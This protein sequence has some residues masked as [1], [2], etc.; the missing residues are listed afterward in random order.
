MD[1]SH[2]VWGQWRWDE[3]AAIPR[4]AP[5]FADDRLASGGAQADDHVRADGLEFS[6]QPRRT[7]C[8]FD[9]AGLF[10]NAALAA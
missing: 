6:L 1:R 5:G 2:D 10:V 7:G 8:D 9:G 4:N 3:N